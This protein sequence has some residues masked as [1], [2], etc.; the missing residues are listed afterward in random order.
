MNETDKMLLTIVIPVYN[1]R[2]LVLRTLR[3]VR[4]QTQRPLSLIVVDNASTDGTLQAVTDWA[5]SFSEPGFN[6][7]ILSE[8]K[9]GAAAAR[10][11]GLK[12][13][14]SPYVMF[15]DSD[16]VMPAGHCK[17]VTNAIVSN[18]YPDILYWRSRIYQLSGRSRI[19]HFATT[20]VLFNHM[21]HCLL[22]TQRYAVRTDLIRQAGGWNESMTGWDDYELGIRLLLKASTVKACPNIKPVEVYAQAESLT[23]TNFSHAPEKWEHALDECE[24]TLSDAGIS[25]ARNWCDMRRAIL[26]G[27]YRREGSAHLAQ[28]LLD[29]AL[30]RGQH[31]TLYKLTHRYVALGGRG[32]AIP[33][34]IFLK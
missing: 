25:Q 33:A 16:D 10:N 4:A 28:R 31:K 21:F 24:R 13:V 17:A 27:H 18:V 19:P 12:H 9:Q 1:R 15:F 6:V 8:T 32:S 20:D 7:Q 5:T 11:C 29:K 22:S 14:A 30:A 23:G 3:S 2:K 26:A 34:K